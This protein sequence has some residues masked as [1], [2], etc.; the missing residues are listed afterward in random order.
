MAPT[1]DHNVADHIAPKGEK[2]CCFSQVLFMNVFPKKFESRI[3]HSDCLDAVGRLPE[4]CLDLIYID[5]PFCTGKRR[6]GE[7]LSLGSGGRIR[8]KKVGEQYNYR[9]VW[10]GRLEGYLEWLK[11]RLESMAILLKPTGS[12]VVH[13]DG[14]ASHYVKV[15]LDEIMGRTNFVNEIIWH[16]KS[17]GRTQRRLARK[18]DSIFWYARG[19]G[20]ACNLDEAAL[21]RN[22]CRLCGSEPKRKNHMKRGIDETGRPVA[23]IKSAG[24]VY[25]Y[26]EDDKAPPCDVWLDIAHLH[27]RDPERTGYPTQKPLKLME[28]IIGLC[29]KPGDS[30]ADFFCGSGATLEAADRMSRKWVGCDAEK[31]AINV[32][33]R[34]FKSIKQSCSVIK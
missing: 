30:V 24:K 19:K 17:G 34:R 23:E 28:R 14:N 1:F 2:A 31:E 20:Y 25:R 6:K 15:L 8:S 29:S 9:D 11:P 21:P 7:N 22:V 26:Y 16:Y 32:V 33:L 18:F 13:L 27:Q 10:E 12:L 3:I 5:P 4:A